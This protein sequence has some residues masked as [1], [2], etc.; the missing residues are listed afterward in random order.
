MFLLVYCSSRV[1]PTQKGTGA[2]E[3]VSKV[4][5]G[6]PK[7]CGDGQQEEHQSWVTHIPSS[8]GAHIQTQIP[9]FFVTKQ[10]ALGFLICNPEK[11]CPCRCS[12]DRTGCTL[13][14]YK[15]KRTVPTH[16]HLSWWPLRF[17][18]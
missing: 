8:P 13:R 4:L 18:A 9:P 10:K 7:F 6:F 14:K 11:L 1:L 17:P 12:T 15:F 2:A 3:G 16:G 5:S